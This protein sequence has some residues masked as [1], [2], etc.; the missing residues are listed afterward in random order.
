MKKQDK[1]STK[2]EYR[3][4]IS[5]FKGLHGLSKGNKKISH[6]I[7]R[8]K[9]KAEVLEEI[10][11]AGPPTKVEIVESERGW[12]SR[13]DEIRSFPNR[14]EAENFVKKY[15]KS[16]VDDSEKNPGVVPDW[17]MYARIIEG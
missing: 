8:A 5:L 10:R 12:G 3:G 4:R 7:L 15:N 14:E 9:I 1:Y 2:K 11:V 16:N 13:T 17:Y 6:G